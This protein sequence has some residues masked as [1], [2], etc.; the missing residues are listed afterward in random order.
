[1]TAKSPRIVV[2]AMRIP[3][4]PVRRVTVRMEPAWLERI[5]VKAVPEEDA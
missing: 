3:S 2:G 5:W 1:M 4:K